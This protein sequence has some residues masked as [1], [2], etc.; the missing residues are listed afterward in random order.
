MWRNRCDSDTQAKQSTVV[1][2]GLELGMKV[3]HNITLSPYVANDS[4]IVDFHN[5]FKSEK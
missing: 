5:I 3:T 4:S 2:K 1:E